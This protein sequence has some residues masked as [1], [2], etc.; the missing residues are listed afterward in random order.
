MVTMMYMTSSG[1]VGL[2]FK[3]K[4]TETNVWLCVEGTMLKGG[5]IDGKRHKGRQSAFLNF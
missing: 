2:A 4:Y 5:R 1:H 3:Q